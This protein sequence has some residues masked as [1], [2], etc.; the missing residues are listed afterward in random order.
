L[1]AVTRPPKLMNLTPVTQLSNVAMSRTSCPKRPTPK[2][3]T[4]FETD[5]IYHEPTSAHLKSRNCIEIVELARSA[6]YVCAQMVFECSKSISPDTHRGKYRVS[7]EYRSSVT[8]V[9]C[10]Y[11][12]REGCHEL[13]LPFLGFP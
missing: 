1:A 4:A 5:I 6:G 12:S 7:S 8:R 13:R 3:D 11:Q 10:W 9:L 2:T